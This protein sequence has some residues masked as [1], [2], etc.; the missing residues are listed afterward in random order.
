MSPRLAMFR[1]I[2]RSSRSYHS[3]SHANTIVN[4]KLPETLLLGQALKHVPELG[5]SQRSISAAVADLNM[6]DSLQLVL[7]ASSSHSPEFLLVLFWLK[8]LRQRLWDHV[9]DKEL[10]F[11]NVANEYD[12]AAYLLKMRLSYN[13]PIAHRMKEALAQLVAPYNWAAALGE[14]HN[15]SDDVA[16]Y[17]GDDSHD[18]AWYAKRLAL[19]SIYVKSEL[20]MLQDRSE[21]YTRTEAFVDS[22]VASLKAAG[23]G[24]NAVEQW[25][26]FTAISTVNLIRSQLARG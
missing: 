4:P 11:H 9:C 24:Y 12:R 10:P 22:S 25:T 7:S 20:F 1:L 5:F 19:S 26:A 18:L 2:L 3:V 21:N 15:L 13:Q 14:L 16:F 17:A 23:A 8:N 6:L